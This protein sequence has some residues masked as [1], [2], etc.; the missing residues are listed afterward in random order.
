LK[1]IY[2]KEKIRVQC[3]CGFIFDK[4]NDY[5]AAIVAVRSHFESFHRDFL[6]FGITDKEV[7]AL[8]NKGRRYIK[9]KVSLSNFN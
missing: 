2:L 9:Q 5:K 3:P 8:I 4:F 6:P 7:L 1:G